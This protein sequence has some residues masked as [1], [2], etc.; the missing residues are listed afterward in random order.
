[1]HNIC[2]AGFRL[3]LKC[4]I[5]TSKLQLGLSLKLKQL[6]VHCRVR[7]TTSVL[8]QQNGRTVSSSGPVERQPRLTLCALIYSMNYML[9]L[10]ALLAQPAAISVLGACSAAG[11]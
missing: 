8:R 7:H 2:H 9:L 1:M 6:I 10:L 4:S 3:S 11:W 5:V